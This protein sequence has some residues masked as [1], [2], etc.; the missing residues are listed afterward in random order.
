VAD[1]EPSGITT[2]FC[3]PSPAVPVTLVVAVALLALDPCANIAEGHIPTN[4]IA[5]RAKVTP[6]FKRETVP[7]CLD[8]IKKQR[9]ACNIII[10]NER[11]ESKQPE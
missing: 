10:N 1:E 3:P 7:Y 5:K 9:P 11:I 4:D 6:I 8:T 2:V